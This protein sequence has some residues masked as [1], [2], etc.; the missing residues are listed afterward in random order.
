MKF[1]YLLPLAFVALF[2]TACEVDESCET[3]AD[4]DTAAGET[5]VITN[6]ETTGTCQGGT[7]V[8]CDTTACPDG[9]NADGTC[10]AACD[11]TACPNGC[12]ADGSCITNTETLDYR[13]VRIDDVSGNFDTPDGG[14]DIDAIVLWK[15]DGSSAY[16]T[17][18]EGFEHGG[19]LGTEVNPQDA[20]NAPD[21]FPDY[22]SNNDA[23]T[24]RVD[25]GFV[26]LGGTGG[27]LVVGM[28]DKME[29]GDDLVVLEVGNCDYGSG[30]ALEDPIDVF[31]SVSNDVDTGVWQVV[32]ESEVGPEIAVTLTATDL[33]DVPVE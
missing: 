32:A 25:G 17:T 18:V 33:P 29:A 3:N 11:T 1:R 21:A 27:Y 31:V 12:N 8:E 14:A 30:M 23:S 10:K 4:C 19:G 20:L 5:C 13:F 28:G 7:V 26:S 2:F 15:A 24:C 6:G 16:A 22:M 9:C